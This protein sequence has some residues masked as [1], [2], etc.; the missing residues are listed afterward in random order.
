V[1]VGVLTLSRAF[2][3]ACGK[4]A[5]LFTSGTAL[6]GRIHAKSC[7]LPSYELCVVMVTLSGPTSNKMRSAV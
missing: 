3:A 7:A 2:S 6:S 1:N 4:T 5:R